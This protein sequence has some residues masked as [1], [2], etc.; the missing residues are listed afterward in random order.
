MTALS[1]LGSST[2]I[3]EKR[4]IPQKGFSQSRRA[5]TRLNKYSSSNLGLMKQSS[6]SIRASSQLL[7]EP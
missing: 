7:K 3:D 1:S 4:L 5:G 6:R 2:V